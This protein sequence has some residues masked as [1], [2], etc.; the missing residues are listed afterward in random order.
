MPS[1]VM[2]EP[3]HIVLQA[4]MNSARLPGKALMPVAGH[5]SAVL[6][7]QRAARAGDPLTVATSDDP[8]CDVLA[9]AMRAAGIPLFRGS[10]QDV[11]GRFIAATRILPDDALVV[12]LTA[13]N[14]FPDSDFV[15]LLVAA[16]QAKD[17]DIIGT[18]SAKG[19]PYGLSGEAF[20]LKALRQAAETD[21]PYDREHVTPWLYRN[22]RSAPFNSLD[23]EMDL[24]HLRCT[25]DMA[26]DY[27]TLTQVFDGVRDPV[28]IGW[29]EL[30]ARLAALSDV[31]QVL[32]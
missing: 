7:A 28:G 25:L 9:A 8:S 2:A 21:V 4:R 30:V 26:D 24:A 23:G 1:P 17:V 31:P 19:L 6:A 10:E 32:A 18:P 11:L 20:R 15:R 22:A 13:D 16:L 3:V 12:R 29:R 5:P 14:I 27:R